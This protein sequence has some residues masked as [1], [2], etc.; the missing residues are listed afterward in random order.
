ML[1]RPTTL[2][3]SLALAALA[4]GAG[5]CLKF[6]DHTVLLPDGSGKVRLTIGMKTSMLALAGQGAKEA[7]GDSDADLAPDVD[8][9]RKDFEGFT[10]FSEPVK[11]TQGDWT[12]F[13]FAGYFEDA[14]KV[15]IW[16]S[17]DED[18]GGERKVMLSLKLT[19]EGEGFVLEQS[20][21]MLDE[22]DD[23]GGDDDPDLPPEAQKAAKD[24][25]KAM[26]KGM[27]E[28]LEIGSSVEM[29]G[30]I[31]KAEGHE[32]PKEGRVA[33]TTVT[34]DDLLDDEKAKKL[35]ERKSTKVWCGKSEVTPEQTKAF[36]DEMTKAKEAWTKRAADWDAKAKAAPGAAPAGPGGMD[37]GSKLP[38]DQR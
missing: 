3:P 16:K 19:K 20:A 9:L 21:G 31:L 17:A 4:L 5:G 10:A 8:E 38:P 33:G 37:D 12:T 15:R 27:M 2:V 26:M 1:R 11:E 30:K 18:E 29:P 22:L 28:G 14:N 34:L 35:K 36:R 24:M 32:M 25:A 6:K 13:T 23:L 7:G